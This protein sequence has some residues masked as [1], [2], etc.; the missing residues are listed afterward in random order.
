MP[1][2]VVYNGDTVSVYPCSPAS[3]LKKGENYTVLK[4]VEFK[5]E[6]NF[7]LEGVDGV[8]SA[9]WFYEYEDIPK[10]EVGV[11]FIT[12]EPVVGE[13]TLI[14]IMNEE[15]GQ[16]ASEELRIVVT[17]VSEEASHIY[18]ITSNNDCYFVKLL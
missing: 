9:D 13:E 4:T 6:E 2:K 1:K 14:N 3:M 8:F 15:D 5:E 18:K 17:D 16:I 11:G 10:N 12:K 7:I